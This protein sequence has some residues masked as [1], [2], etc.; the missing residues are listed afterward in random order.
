[1]K[2]YLGELIKQKYGVDDLPLSDFTGEVIRAYE[3]YLKTEKDLCQNTL[4]RYMKALKKITNRC[5]ANDWIQ[6]NPFAGIKFREDP[7]GPE[8][9]TLEEVDR[10]YNSTWM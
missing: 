4:I 9:L 7:T 8:F 10:I 6:K 3:V 5:L 2:R 1:M